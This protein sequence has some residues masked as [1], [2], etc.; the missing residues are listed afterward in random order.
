MSR[1]DC[2]EAVAH[3]YDYLKLELTPDLV[4]EVRTHLDRCCDCAGHARFEQ[5]FLQ[6]LE[7]RVSKETCPNEVRAR[8]VAALRAAARGS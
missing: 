8:I 7:A 4:E 2:E 3:L 6:M 5:Q 1:L